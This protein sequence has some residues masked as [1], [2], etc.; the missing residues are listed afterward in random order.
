MVNI[1]YRFFVR[2]YDSYILFGCR[3]MM[4][5]P[6]LLHLY[7]KLL[8]KG[9][10]QSKCSVDGSRIVEDLFGQDECEDSARDGSSHKRFS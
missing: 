5:R 2:D 3:V 10:W 1:S 9:N 8:S 4:V 6:T 7:A